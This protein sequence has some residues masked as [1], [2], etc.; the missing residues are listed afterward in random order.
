MDPDFMAEWSSNQRAGNQHGH[1]ARRFLAMLAWL[2]PVRSHAIYRALRFLYRRIPVGLERKMPWAQHLLRDVPQLQEI[3]YQVARADGL[4]PYI[5]AYLTPARL[6]GPLL[7]AGRRIL[8]VEHRLPTPDRNSSSV[9][10]YAILK[11]MR[12]L[13]WQVTFVSNTRRSD[14]CTFLPSPERELPQYERLLSDLDIRYLYGMDALLE[15]L[16]SEGG[17][18]QFA[19]LSYPEI[20]HQYASVARALMVHSRIL[21]DMVDFHGL[22]FAREARL[23]NP[24]AVLLEKAAYYQRM[25]LANAEC[26]DTVVAISE[27]EQREIVRYV[28]GLRSTVIP[29]IHR[30]ECNTP[31]FESRAGLLFIGHYLHAPNADAVTYFIREVLPL[32]RLQLPEIPFYVLGSCMPPDLRQYESGS[33]HMV[34]YV[35]DPAPWFAKARVFVAPLRFGAGMKGKIGQSLGLGVPV[36][37]TEIGAEGMHLEDGKNALIAKS[38]RDFAS[39]VVRLHQDAVLWRRLVRDGRA[40]VEAYFSEECALGVLRGL[41]ADGPHADPQPGGL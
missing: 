13:D 14:Y 19:F 27:A 1:L 16:Q 17:T 26:A 18:Y 39:A 24:D 11:L 40:H 20:M 31:G 25:E 41:L 3:A 4:P 10:L 22:R 29:N 9:R 23:L 33:T 21:Y 30:V 28:P 2:L 37:T 38:P 15:H 34:G 32:I 36:V 12:E 6:E 5:G 7:P 8:V 35:D